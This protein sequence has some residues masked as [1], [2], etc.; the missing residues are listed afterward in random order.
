MNLKN[1]NELLNSEDESLYLLRF[2]DKTIIIIKNNNPSK[3]C[4]SASVEKNLK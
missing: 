3:R 2:E 4:K 1:F